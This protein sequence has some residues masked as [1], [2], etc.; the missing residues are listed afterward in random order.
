GTCLVMYLMG[1]I[2]LERIS[3]GAFII[4]LCMLTDNAIVVTEGIKVGIEAGKDKLTV[5]RDVVAHNQWPLFGA[6]AI[7]VVAFAAIGLSEDN[8]GEYTNWL[9][10][11]IFISL[12]LSWVAAITFTPLL[13]YRLF[14]PRAE[15]EAERNPYGGLLYRTYR[16]F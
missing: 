16:R 7:A 1:G 11:V 3:L 2:L 6:T 10:W 4:A 13:A 8:T 14:T 5:I 9:F 15:G 12:A